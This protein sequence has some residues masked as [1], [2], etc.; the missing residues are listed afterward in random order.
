[1]YTIRPVNVDDAAALSTIYA[2]YVRETTVTFEY[3]PPSAEEFAV[4]IRKISAKYPY[5][6]CLEGD[7]PIGYAYANHFRARAA[8]DWDVETSIYVDINHRHTGA[9]RLLYEALETALREQGIVTLYAC[10]T[11]PNPDSIAFHTAR[12]FKQLAVFPRAGFKHG[13]WHDVTW[14][15]KQINEYTTPPKE[16]LPWNGRTK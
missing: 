5:F 16:I 10:V 2:P 11:S 14:M 4:R 6:V 7:T 12:G 3:D 9:G 13:R 15:V 8:Y 1:M